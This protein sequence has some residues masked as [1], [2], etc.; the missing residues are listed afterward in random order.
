MLDDRLMGEPREAVPCSVCGEQ[1]PARP[2]FE[3]VGFTI[4]RCPRCKV[5][6][7]S[8]RLTTSGLKAYYGP[9]YWQSGDSV[10]R[11]YFDYRGDEANI[12]RT[13]QRR[14]QWLARDLP[15]AGRLLDLG[16]AC[17]FLLDTARSAG[18]DVSGVE[19]S[20]HIRI[21]A[22]AAVRSCIA[23][24]LADLRLA[25]ASLDCVT[26]W[27]YLEHSQDPRQE[28]EAWARLLKPGGWMSLIVPDAGSWLA[29]LL[30]SRWEEFKKPRE[31]LYFFTGSQLKRLLAALG[32]RV[33]RRR[34]EGKYASLKFAFS[35]FKPGDGLLHGASRLAWKLTQT[36]GWE[37]SVAY[38]NPHDKLHLLAR[39]EA[40][41]P[42]QA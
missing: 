10:E 39:K 16:C 18:W 25:D 19:W 29:R 17:G 1:P 11:G 30:G 27:D 20:E 7:V 21:H 4:V 35:R 26:A 40:P 34:Y 28:L 3:S 12:R 22:P 38:I 8:P 36:M 33:M 24:N 14:W 37:N 2:A 32:L 9:D 6:R 31:H 41:S 42:S 13:F 15:S 23:A 5:L